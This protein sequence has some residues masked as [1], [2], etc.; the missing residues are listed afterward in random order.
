MPCADPIMDKAAASFVGITVPIGT[1][2]WYWVKF[3]TNAGGLQ[4]R[5]GQRHAR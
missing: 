1:P 5:L 3:T 4:L 2:H